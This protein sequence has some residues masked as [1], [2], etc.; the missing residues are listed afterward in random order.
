[1]VASKDPKA[2]II[3][4]LRF[5][6]HLP[7]FDHPLYP[8]G[9]PRSVAILDALKRSLPKKQTHIVFEIASQVQGLTGRAPHVEFALAAT[10]ILLRLPRGSGQGMFLVGRSVGWIAHAIE[11]YATGA[12]IRPRA[13][14][15]GILPGETQ[16]LADK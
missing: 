1:L 6:E 3:E 16:Y 4:R 10:S 11:Q 12:R 5:G 9:D 13:R 8:Q 2:G 14:Y 7:G 15:V